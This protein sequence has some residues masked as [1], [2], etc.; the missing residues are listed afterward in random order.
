MSKN[1]SKNKNHSLR[2]ILF[3]CDLN[4]IRSPIAESVMKVWF[5]KKI[6][7]D[8]CG[9]RP[10]K[11]DPLAIEVMTELNYDLSNHKSKLI[12]QLEDN[13]FDLIIT[14]SQDS[15]DASIIFTKT[16]SC[17]VE[18]FDVPDASIT[19]GNREQRLLSYRIVRD[20]IITKLKERFKYYL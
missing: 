9:V 5:N 14:F 19:I 2:S 16:V 1:I 13:Y 15:Y 11:I 20:T 17:E 18:M 8:S 4:S 12:T 7:I 10:G 6:F 3:I